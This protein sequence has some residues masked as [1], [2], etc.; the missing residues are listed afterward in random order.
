MTPIQRNLTVYRGITFDFFVILRAA[1]SEI[2]T[3]TANASTDTITTATPHGLS[4]ADPIQFV[5]YGG[6]LPSPI[7]TGRNYFVLST[8][9]TTTFTFSQEY[10]GLLFDITTAGTPTS[11]VFT[12]RPF[13][14][15]GW[16]VWSWVKSTPISGTLILDLDPQIDV[17]PTTGRVDF[18]MTDE[19]T[20]VLTVGD[21]FWDFIL[22]RPTGERIGPLFTGGFSIV[23][24]I[25]EPPE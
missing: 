11:K 18:S 24:L 10:N 25:T 15:T 9:T 4:V 13:D 23:H 16:T 1:L 20:I 22:E 19:E 17:D 8:P 21:F 14:L 7:E 6:V 5:T 2:D 12:N 3:F